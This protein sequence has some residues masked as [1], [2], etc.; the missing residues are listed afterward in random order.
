MRPP[1]RKWPFEPC[2]VPPPFSPIHP[3]R[4]VDRPGTIYGICKHDP[5]TVTLLDDTGPW[6]LPEGGKR[7]ETKGRFSS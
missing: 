6:R 4:V 3:V 5:E 2:C 7:K 1:G